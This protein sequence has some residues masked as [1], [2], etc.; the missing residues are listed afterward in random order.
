MTEEERIDMNISPS[1]NAQEKSEILFFGAYAAF[2]LVDKMIPM[3]VAWVADKFYKLHP[4][5]PVTH[6]R[7]LLAASLRRDALT[8]TR[9]G[10]GSIQ[11]EGR[12]G[13]WRR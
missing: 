12:E 1:C 13:H 11:K 5:G 9:S 6:C 3:L 2:S 8:G 10:E 4:E 7:F